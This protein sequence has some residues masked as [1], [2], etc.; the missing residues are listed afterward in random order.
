MYTSPTSA[1]G[2]VRSRVRGKRNRKREDW[3]LSHLKK[4]FR[5]ISKVG[6]PMTT[7]TLIK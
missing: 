4:Y 7:F 5:N 1:E 3:F 6:L 2:A